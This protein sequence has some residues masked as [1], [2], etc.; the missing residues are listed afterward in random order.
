MMLEGWPTWI[1]IPCAQCQ[2]RCGKEILATMTDPAYREGVGENFST[3]EG[4][5]FCSADCLDEYD[6]ENKAEA[7]SEA[8][9]NQE[10]EG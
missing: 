2:E 4:I 7:L 1:P 8:L 3:A 9:D 10:S 5:W 6:R